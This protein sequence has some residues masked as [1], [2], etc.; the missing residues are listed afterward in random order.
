MFKFKKDRLPITLFAAYFGVDLMVFFTAERVDFLV[1]WMLLGIVP[2]AF[3]SSWNHHHQHVETFATGCW[4]SS[5]DF[6]QGLFPTGGSCI[7][8]SDIM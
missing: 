2:K 8:F 1:F 3:I 6:R 4:R 7:T 5:T